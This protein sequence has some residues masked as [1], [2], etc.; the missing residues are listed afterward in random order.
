MFTA[1]PLVA[2]VTPARGG[3]AP[4]SL[5]LVAEMGGGGG[6]QPVKLQLGPLL[7]ELMPLATLIAALPAWSF[8]ST[9]VS[10]NVPPPV[11]ARCVPGMLERIR[12]LLASP[13][14]GPPPLNWIVPPF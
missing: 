2:L 1:P 9:S 4:P 14:A 13:Q 7:P 6:G 12:I 8:T 3:R 10:E 5:V 11:Q